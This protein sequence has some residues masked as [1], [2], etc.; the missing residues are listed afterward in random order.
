[1]HSRSRCGAAL[2]HQPVKPMH[3]TSQNPWKTG[4]TR[5]NI[6]HRHTGLA[7]TAWLQQHYA[8]AACVL[9]TALPQQVN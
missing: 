1:M 5:T 6:D 9:S 7:P 8:K 2:S 3:N 4:L